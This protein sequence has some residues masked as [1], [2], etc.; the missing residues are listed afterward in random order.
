MLRLLAV[1]AALCLPAALAAA[2]PEPPADTKYMQFKRQKAWV[3][4]SRY[5]VFPD[6]RPQAGVPTAVMVFE[7]GPF[8]NLE[9]A[10]PVVFET[11][12]ARS[13]PDNAQFPYWELR[14]SSPD[15]TSIDGASIAAQ[16][17]RVAGTQAWYM[18]L[19]ADRPIATNQF[20][21]TGEHLMYCYETE[22][23]QAA[24]WDLPWPAEWP[25]DT[26]AWL[27]RDPSYD[28]PAADGS[29]PVQALIDRWTG[30]NDP[31]Q[32]PPVQ[33]AKFMTGHVLDHVR[34]NGTNSEQPFGRPR[35]ILRDGR[36]SQV[37]LV[38]RTSEISLNLNGLMGG[39]RIQNAA[40]IASMTCPFCWS[41]CSAG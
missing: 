29:D 6:G 39:F 34:S 9:I 41:P 36:G 16:R 20:Q 15:D 11:A 31:K 1:L 22:F 12:N 25:A 10:V 38:G 35:N 26:A 7:G 33:L 13:D 5:F 4:T 30:G 40:E 14:F 37:R 18:L 24:A 21:I 32:I 3:V 8:E 17:T 27:T 23:N 19:K 2:A 28:L